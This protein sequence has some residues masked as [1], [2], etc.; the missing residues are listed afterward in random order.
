MQTCGSGYLVGHR[1]ILTARHVVVD[2]VGLE[3]P[4]VE[5]LLGHPAG[6]QRQRYAARVQWQDPALDLLLMRLEGAPTMRGSAVRFGLFIT[7]EPAR[8]EGL[9]FPRFSAY[10]SGGGVEQ[11]G[12]MLPPLA[13]GANGGYV[14][15]QSAAPRPDSTRAWGGA[16]GAAVFC[17]GLLVGVVSKDDRDFANQR[18]HAVRITTALTKPEFTRL[19]AEDTGTSIA[20]EAVELTA[21]LQPPA[22]P[23]SARTPGS[24]LAADVEAVAFTGREHVLGELA[25]WRDSNSPTA[26]A[27][28]AGEGGQG[29]TRLAREFAART[30]ASGWIAGFTRAPSARRTQRMTESAEDLGKLL[31]VSSRPILIVADYAETH[32]DDIAAIMEEVQGQSLQSSIRLLLLARAVGAWWEGL[33]ETLPVE[34]TRLI[35]LPPLTDSLLEREK[36]YAAAVVGL[37]RH[38][39]RLSVESGASNISHDWDLLSRQLADAPPDLSDQRLGN[40]LTLHMIALTDLLAM[41]SGKTAQRLGRFEERELTIHEYGYLRRIAAKR[42][43]FEQG[44]LSIRT[45]PHDRVLE[46]WTA[47]ER[48]LGGLILLGPGDIS[49]VQ[50]ISLLTSSDRILDVVAWLATLYP[51][52]TNWLSLG[53]VQPDRLAELLLGGILSRHPT[54]LSQIAALVENLEDAVSVLLT[55]LRTA[56]HPQ[57][58]AIGEQ[59]R[60]LVLSRPVPFAGAALILAITLAHAAS[61][62]GLESAVVALE[63]VSRH[64][65]SVLGADHPNALAAAASMAS[66]RLALVR[67]AVSSRSKS[68]E[69]SGVLRA[70]KSL[71]SAELDAGPYRELAETSPDFLS[72]L[73][74]LALD[75]LDIRQIEVP[76]RVNEVSNQ[77]EPTS[78]VS[79]IASNEEH[80]D[81]FITMYNL[82]YRALVRLAALLVRDVGTAE[83]VVQESFL[84]MYSA[85]SRLRDEE[86]VLAYIRQAVVNRSR[87]VLRHRTVVDRNAPKPPPDAPSSEEEAITMLE[88]AAVVAAL[89]NLPPRQREALVLRYYSDLTRAEIAVHMGVDNK[90]VSSYMSRGRSALR[91]A[92]EGTL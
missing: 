18:L 51:P 40:A 4:R 16:S 2:E 91:K 3:W 47:L 52:P 24:L 87:S 29:K 46:A 59:A 28:V 89:K 13:V 86:K 33:S 77:P 21:F 88:H 14:L 63:I 41:G 61:I 60:A 71:H 15:D 10:D 23:A 9:G 37:A 43:L 22:S 31:R 90:S 58:A 83:E 19:V 70:N 7:G 36:A 8:Y 49:H 35:E 75:I 78:N 64:A 72:G 38:L 1:L 30:Q 73:L 57:Y 12:G 85:M 81:L 68:S 62:Q 74:T 32:P 17:E 92:L 80:I 76:D 82:H 11:L 48:A 53:P 5:V 79:S 69:N 66:A 84:A 50:T 42:G 56:A 65:E 39:K 45:D 44:V 27:L 34:D 6:G 55:L 67:D 25:D 26:I 54:L 20:I